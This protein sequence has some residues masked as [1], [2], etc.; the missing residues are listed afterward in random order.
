MAAL[1]EIFARFTTSFD[2]TALQK[3]QSAITAVTHGLEL[4]ERGIQGVKNATEFLVGDVVRSGVEL[5]RQASRLG[6]TTKAMEE[7]GFVARQAGKE[8]EDV[9]DA[10]STLQERARDAIID[11]ESDPAE[12][13]RLLGVSATD[14]A[15]NLK[16]AE[17]LF[18]EVSDGIQGMGNQTDRVGAVMTLFGDVGRELLPVLQNGSEGIDRLRAEFEALGGGLS[19]EAI[20]KSSE[21]I[22]A[23]SRLDAV[24][25]SL[26]STIA[27]V[28]LPVLTRLTEAF[29]EL[30]TN[31]AAINS[32]K[33]MLTVLAG[34]I[35]GM[36]LPAIVEATIAMAAFAAPFIPVIAAGAAL[37][38][39]LQDIFTALDGGKSLFGDL[40]EA[41]EEFF[42]A[43]RTGTGPLAVFSRIWEGLVRGMERAFNVMDA[44]LHLDL[45]RIRNFNAAG[46]GGARGRGVGAGVGITSDG[47]VTGPNAPVAPGAAAGA[48]V[49]V[50]NNINGAMDPAAVATQIER[51][52]SRAWRQALEANVSRAAQ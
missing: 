33:L 14:A 28:F 46:T 45:D 8:T 34:V 44:I 26:R 37:F 2:T 12:Q 42:E 5:E 17:Q 38:L 27:L 52:G 49:H 11:P 32:L 40:T 47:R 19:E 6:L 30:A 50:T 21:F 48:T 18:N 7:Y 4:V 35:T 43:N 24:M 29:A 10:M 13:L 23:L 36:F 1:R 9:V 22:Q 20:E 25:T 51:S 31:E 3:G 16:S 39:I 15:G 41:M